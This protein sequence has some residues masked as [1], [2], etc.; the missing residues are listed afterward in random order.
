MLITSPKG[1]F[2]LRNQAIKPTSL[3]TRGL[4]LMFTATVWIQ[5]RPGGS[6]FI[7]RTV[8]QTVPIAI[9]ESEEKTEVTKIPVNAN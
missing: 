2:E 6:E 7:K 3:D 5:T 4:D 8:E 1:A 9:F